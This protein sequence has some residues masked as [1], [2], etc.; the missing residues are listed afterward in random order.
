MPPELLQRVFPKVERSARVVSASLRWVMGS[1][2]LGFALLAIVQA[3]DWNQWRGPSRTGIAAAFT[4]PAAWPE[5]PQRAWQVKVGAGHSSPVV[6]GGRVYQ[7]ARLGEQEVV[8]AIDLA[9]GKQVW[10]QQYEALYQMNPAAQGHGKGPKSTPAAAGAR[11]FT[12]GI[13]GTLS[14]FD[15]ASGKVLW[16]RQYAK[17]FDAS[18]PDFG[19]AMSP[20]VES[21]LLVVH[22]GG[23]TS[24]ALVA[25][26]AAT[27]TEKWSWKGDGPAYASP[28]VATFGKTRHVITQSRS[29]VVGIRAAD[30][31]LLWRIPLTTA[32][33][34]NIVTP[35]VVDDLLVYSGIDK[36]LTAVRIAEAAGKW[37]PEPVWQN[38]D[39]PMYMS[40]PVHA[41]GYLFGLTHRN[42]GQ[43]FAVDLK[44]G[45]T[46]W[47][48]RGREGDN[49]A[50]VVAGDL[51]LAT[52]TEGELVIARQDPAKFDAIRRYTVA[53]SPIWAHPVPAGRGVLIKDAE[54]LA[55]W[56]F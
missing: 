31:S 18:S 44:T 55:L 10:Q 53:G 12:F 54:T 13:N 27:G 34:Q 7:F 38:A 23:N 49:A 22:V 43:F 8:T 26:D 41:G 52:T 17:E 32:Y 30:G 2:V 46:M 35:L 14:A 56:T 40:S 36:P 47:T 15:A 1:V 6:S 42:R 16:R 21:G 39:L 24:G 3:Q 28:V 9:S 51:L 11:L 19:V 48:T 29:H 20:M 25:L 33:D 37:T 5:R 4:A 45:K 50:L